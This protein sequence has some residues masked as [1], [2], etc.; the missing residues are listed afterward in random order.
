VLLKPCAVLP[1][2]LLAGCST[3]VARVTPASPAPSAVQT[4][5][6]RHVRNAVDAGNGDLA[7]QR[8]QKQVSASPDD[9]AAR[10]QLAQAYENIGASE[11]ALDHLR[12]ARRLQPSSAALALEEARL[13]NKS[14]LTSQAVAC[15]EAYLQANPAA[16]PSVQSWLG[17]YR[18]QSGDLAGGE[19]AH[20]A[21]LALDPSSALLLNNLGYNLLQ[22]RRYDDAAVQL[23]AALSRD[24]GLASARSNL[25]TALAGRTANPDT[26][27]A[28]AHWLTLGDAAAAHNNLAAVYIDQKRYREA[29]QEL[30]QAL[31]YN[32]T[33]APALRNLQL[34]A[35]LDGG[36]TGVP[37]APR[38]SSWS[39]FTAGL[40]NVFVGTEEVTPRRRASR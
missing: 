8:L 37:A 39:R 22:Q 11:L 14:G 36:R 35:D 12:A 1:L 24:R 2:I 30:Q 23:Q 10:R 19:T 7:L 3:K 33:F 9:L 28:L 18:D 17:I 5:F 38:P 26:K 32:R 21:A 27:A 15:L 25:A 13:L 20:R 40:K 6:D 31:N 34:I 4:T 29:R 16:P